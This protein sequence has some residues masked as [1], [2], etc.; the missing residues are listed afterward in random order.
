MPE[1]SR[2]IYK[3]LHHFEAKKTQL[4]DNQQCKKNRCLYFVYTFF[5]ALM[6]IVRIFEVNKIKVK[7]N[8]KNLWR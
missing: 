4:S 2:C 3:K 6:I 1:K 8:F 5:L 7:F